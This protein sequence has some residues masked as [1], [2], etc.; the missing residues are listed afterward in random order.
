MEEKRDRVRKKER[1]LK[2]DREQEKID[3]SV[4]E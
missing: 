3:E 1:R 2:R 4:K